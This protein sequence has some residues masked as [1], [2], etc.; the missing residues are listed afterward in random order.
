MS[1]LICAL[2]VGVSLFFV[3]VGDPS[4]ARVTA[5]ALLLGGGIV[6]MHYV[7]IHGLAGAFTIEH[8]H[9]MVALAAL[10]AVCTAYGG[11][12]IFLAKHVGRRLA[13]SAV[14]FG[15]AASGM[16]YTA[17]YGMHFRVT[18]EHAHMDGGLVASAQV[19]SL[20]VALLCFVIAAGFLLI[21][22][23][24]PMQRQAPTAA[25]V[26]DGQQPVSATDML[27]EGAF[28]SWS[29]RAPRGGQR[30]ARRRLAGWAS[31]GPR[32]C[33]GY[34][35]RER[36]AS[37]SSMSPMCAASGPT[38]ITRRCTTARASACRHGRSRRPRR[39][40]IRP[41]SAGPPQPHCCNSPRQLRAQGG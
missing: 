22:V 10:I 32:L 5:S 36:M 8:D 38:R 25:A 4:N 23:P 39:S 24:D 41:F 27:A 18:P 7:G 14:A 11:L 35:S 26:D 29:E 31:H 16:H 19:L 30:A 21:L 33:R 12:R 20:V 6:S 3:S 40:S 13:L 28:V 34:R 37:I 17:M 1:F 9:A 15:I 2:V